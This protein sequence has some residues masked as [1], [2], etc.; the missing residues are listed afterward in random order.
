MINPTLKVV[1]TLVDGFPKQNPEPAPPGPVVFRYSL[2][3]TINWRDIDDRDWKGFSW[4][5]STPT[6]GSNSKV[7]SA[8]ECSR[9]NSR[10]SYCWLI[11][12][13]KSLFTN[14]SFLKRTACVLHEPS[15]SAAGVRQTTAGCW[16]FPASRWEFIS[17]VET[18]EL[19]LLGD[20]PWWPPL[21][22]CN[23]VH[24][25]LDLKQGSPLQRCVQIHVL[26]ELRWVVQFVLTCV[27]YMSYFSQVTKVVV[28]CRWG[29]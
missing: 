24:K 21:G 11:L 2:K 19:W 7:K 5:E 14:A 12:T 10:S 9:E 4:I 3:K 15:S 28:F 18:F 6:S 20:L 17:N 16:T 1:S 22:R 8:F 29:C 25:S 13:I 27:S 26:H 23:K